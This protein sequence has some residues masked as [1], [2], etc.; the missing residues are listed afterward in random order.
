MAP[1]SPGRSG[2]MGFRPVYC[3]KARRTALFLNVPPWT[4]TFLPRVFRLRIRI[5]FVNTLLMIERQIPAIMSSG[6]L[7]SRCSVMMELFM[8]TVQREPS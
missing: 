3:S 2:R 6:C 4:T 1:I 7:P 8:N 5:T